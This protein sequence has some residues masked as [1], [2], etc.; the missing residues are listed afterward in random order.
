MGSRYQEWGPLACGW[1]IRAGKQPQ[2]SRQGCAC[3]EEQD[4]CSLVRR[5]QAGLERQVQ[6]S[7]MAH[8][9]GM[10]RFCPV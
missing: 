1:V 8:G 3:S 2:R 6:G 4:V 9:M 7:D 5:E 10:R